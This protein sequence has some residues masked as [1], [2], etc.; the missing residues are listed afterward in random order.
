MNTLS[1]LC[2]GRNEMRTICF[3]IVIKHEV[4]TVCP[5]QGFFFTSL[6][7]SPAHMVLH[8]SSYSLCKTVGNFF[9]VSLAVQSFVPFNTFLLKIFFLSLMVSVSSRKNALL[10]PL[11]VE[12]QIEN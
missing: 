8:P 7:L 9:S 6:S 1:V 2:L 5:L 3:N 11:H 10:S 4:N 12:N